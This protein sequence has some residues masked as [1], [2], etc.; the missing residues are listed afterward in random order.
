MKVT[1]KNPPKPKKTPPRPSFDQL[2]EGDTFAFAVAPEKPL[3]MSDDGSF[4]ELATGIA[5]NSHTVDEDEEVILLDQLKPLEFV[6][7]PN[8]PVE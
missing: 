3:L 4:V 2:S 6:V 7:R 8:Q 1:V 5:T